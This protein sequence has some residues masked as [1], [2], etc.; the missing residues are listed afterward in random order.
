[1]GGLTMSGKIDR[2]E[3]NSAEFARI[4]KSPEVQADIQRRLNAIAAAAGPGEFIVE[5]TVGPNR[6]HGEVRTGDK[7]ARKSEAVNRSLTSALGAGGG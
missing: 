2:I 6:V 3:Y 4:L 5:V 1:M 7:V